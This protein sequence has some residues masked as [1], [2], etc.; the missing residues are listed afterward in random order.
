MAPSPSGPGPDAHRAFRHGIAA[1][2]VLALAILAVS[3]WAGFLSEIHVAFALVVGGPVY[4]V[5]AASALSVWLGFDK[6]DTD[7]RPVHREQSADGELRGGD[8]A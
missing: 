7:L 5:I 4:L 6:D 2:A 8:D 3:Y 1:A